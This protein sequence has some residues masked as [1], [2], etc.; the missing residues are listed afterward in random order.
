[1]HSGIR[2]CQKNVNRSTFDSNGVAHL[3]QVRYDPPQVVSGMNVFQSMESISRVS[4]GPRIVMDVPD[5][6]CGPSPVEG[7]YLVVRPATVRTD[8]ISYS[9]NPRPEI[10]HQAVEL[11]RGLGLRIVVVADIQPGYEDAL[12][13]M[14]HG[15]VE[16]LKGELTADQLLALV[17][18]AR[19]VVAPV[20][21]VVP[22]CMA[23]D[24]PLL[25]IMGGQGAYNHPTRLSDPRQGKL[26]I[27]WAMPDPFCMCGDVT[28]ECHRA[29]PDLDS[30]FR[31]FA[32][33]VRVTA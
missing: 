9:R 15:D 4:L 28:H 23:M 5:E 22:A 24:V 33:R 6:V 27:E 10:L 13:P 14:P 20:G 11:A 1:M 16:W 12:E 32:D 2:T 21:W 25:C 31:R 26:P 17:F 7:D 8:W 19:G 29:I 3:L 30:V 18:H